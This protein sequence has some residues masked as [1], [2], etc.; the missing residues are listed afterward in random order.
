[1]DAATL[2]CK[3]SDGSPCE[4]AKVMV[5][6]KVVLFSILC[7]VFSLYILTNFLPAIYDETDSQYSAASKEMIASEDWLIPTNN[8]VPR[9]HK[10]PLVYFTQ[11]ISMKIFGV[12]EFSARL[13]LDLA[14]IGWICLLYLIVRQLGSRNLALLT[15]LILSTLFGFFIFTHIIMPEPFLGFFLTLTFYAFIRGWKDPQA[16]SRWFLLAWTAMAFGTMSKGLHAMLY[17]L[18]TAGIVAWIRPQSRSFWKNIFSPKGIGLF[19]LIVIPWYLYVEHRFPG[20]IWNQ[21]VNEQIGHVFHK[22]WPPSANQVPHLIFWPQHLILWLPWSLFIPAAIVSIMKNRKR[23]HFDPVILALLVVWTAITF[24]SVIFSSRQDYYTMTAWGTIALF[25]AIPW[26]HSEK[27]A[28]GYY[29]VPCI[30]IGLAG[31]AGFA[32]LPSLAAATGGEIIPTHERDRIYS[33]IAGISSEFWR[34]LIPS[35]LIASSSFL[36]A[37]AVALYYIFH[38]RL[39]SAFA[40]IACMMALN[41]ALAMWSMMIN[42]EYFTLKQVAQDIDRYP[43]KDLLVVCEGPHHVAASLFFYSD[44][45]IHWVNSDLKNEFVAQ[46]LKIADKDFFTEDELIEKWNSLKP[47]VLITEESELDEWKG[48]LRVSQWS[49][50][51]R[52]GTRVAVQNQPARHAQEVGL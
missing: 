28:R 5:T 15:A 52:S 36:I 49:I 38:R 17:P 23:F 11:I 26:W 8:Q 37:G 25:L 48:K 51:S 9:L 6:R 34:N 3:T 27:V 1:M 30:L 24:L 19:I 18:V 22:R 39:Y 40:T 45:K 31:I 44:R 46:D 13:P 43:S 32:I 2:L 42:E 41:I 7:L 16:A 12:N 50:L 47:V 4:A 20:F 10:P 21:L 14:T 29:A 35:I 33:T